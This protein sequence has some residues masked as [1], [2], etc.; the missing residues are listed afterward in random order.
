L[1]LRRLVHR[2]GEA[3]TRPGVDDVARSEFEEVAL[4]DGER[5]LGGVVAE[6]RDLAERIESSSYF[7]T[8]DWV[9]GWWEDRGRPRTVLGLWR[10]ASGRL[11]AVAFL[12]NV[13]EP[14]R[15]GFPVTIP[16]VANS[17]SGRPYSADRCGWPVLSHRAAEVRDWILTNHRRESLLL[18]H[19]DSRTEASCVPQGARRV[20]TTRCPVLESTVAGSVVPAS[21][22]LAKDFPRF[23]RRLEAMGVSFTW[24]PPGQMTTDALDVLFALHA[25]SRSA[26]GGSSFTPELHADLHRRLIATGRPGCGP[27]MALAAHEGRPI[28][29]NYGFVWRDTLY[30]YQAGWDISYAKRRLGTVLQ[31][32]TIRLA[33]LNGLHRVD[34]LR[35]VEAHKYSWGAH[36]VIDETW[37]RPRGM[38]GW[39]LS[40]KFRFARAEQ[41]RDLRRA[42]RPSARPATSSP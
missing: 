20:L 21:K 38:R 11:E 6:W 25:S 35:G 8:P 13:R 40:Q 5:Q 26:R 30:G 22:N 19:L 29:I 14:L 28:G 7:Q 1:S 9:L 16:V 2:E 17:G 24:T 15:R 12:S 18:R 42:G 3:S 34:Y 37:L 39:V 41:A 31:G 27:A 32:E 33:R 23:R 36:D 10:D 4:R